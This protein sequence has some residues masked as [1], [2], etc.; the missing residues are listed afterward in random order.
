[1]D[2]ESKQFKWLETEQLK[3]YYREN[4]NEYKALEINKFDLADA[5]NGLVI[6]TFDLLEK[7]GYDKE[8]VLHDEMKKVFAEREEPR[9]EMKELRQEIG[10]DNMEK[11]H[12][13]AEFLEKKLEL[14]EEALKERGIS[15]TM[16]DGELS[17]KEV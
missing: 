14:I 15:V 8:Q 12:K 1:M 17:F 16:K 9:K 5:K 10:N 3:Q 7:K 6:S 4:F 2:R 13:K 11:A